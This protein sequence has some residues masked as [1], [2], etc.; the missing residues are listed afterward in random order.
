MYMGFGEIVA[1][2]IIF[3]IL[4]YGVHKSSVYNKENGCSASGCANCGASAFCEDMDKK[5]QDNK[6]I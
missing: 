1:I 2:V 6:N 5:E 4:A 3:A